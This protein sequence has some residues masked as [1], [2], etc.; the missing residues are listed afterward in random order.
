MSSSSLEY[1]R[2]F[3]VACRRC[4]AAIGEQCKS[5]VG[6]GRPVATHTARLND[7]TKAGL[8]IERA[9]YEAWTPPVAPTES[10]RDPR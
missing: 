6:T 7:A 5:S 2:A 4:G 8:S 1:R 3:P 9:G 10:L